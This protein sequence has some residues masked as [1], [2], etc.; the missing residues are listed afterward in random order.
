M[1]RRYTTRAHTVHHRVHHRRMRSVSPRVHRTHHTHH[2]GRGH[3]AYNRFVS[4]HMKRLGSMA[5]VA[6]L[7]R[8]KHH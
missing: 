8:S 2:T 6:Q 7:W 1:P 3:S 4:T 5:A